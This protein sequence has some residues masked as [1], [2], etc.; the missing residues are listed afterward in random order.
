[1]SSPGPDA[2]VA[3]DQRRG[4]E[5]AVASASASVDPTAA[6]RPRGEFTFRLLDAISHKPEPHNG[7]KVR[8]T[9]HMV[10]LGAE[11]RV[12]VTSLQMVGAS[13]GN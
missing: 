2:I 3:A 6:T 8:V 9:G 1:M 11:V 10:R 5:E 13:C 4:V 7:H 12:N